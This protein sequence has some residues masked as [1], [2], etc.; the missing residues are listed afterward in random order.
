MLVAFGGALPRDAFADVR[1]ECL[2][3]FL[4]CE[5]ELEFPASS[6]GLGYGGEALGE[7]PVDARDVGG[8]LVQRR[9]RHG[10]GEITN[11]A[12]LACGVVECFCCSS[13]GWRGKLPA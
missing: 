2:G 5:D 7:F 11:G 3:G 4:C 10:V 9:A 1:A 8:L 12:E 6:G 13:V